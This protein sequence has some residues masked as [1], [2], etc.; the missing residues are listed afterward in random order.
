MWKT[1]EKKTGIL[2]LLVLFYLNQGY[3]TNDKRI[4]AEFILILVSFYDCTY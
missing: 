2:D 3:L 1:I 4:R